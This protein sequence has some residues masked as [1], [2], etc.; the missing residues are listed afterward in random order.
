MPSIAFFT[1][2]S[3]FPWSRQLAGDAGL[4]GEWRFTLNEI[5]EDCEFLV[6]YDEVGQPFETSLP[7]ERRM[8]ILSEPPGIKTYHPA[9]LDQFGIVM[10]PIEPRDFKGRWIASH[11]ALPWFLGIGFGK[12]GLEVNLDLEALRA[13]PCPPKLNAISVVISS[14]A[15]LPKHRARLAFVEKLQARLGEQLHVFG[16]GFREIDDKAEAILPYAYHLVLENNDIPHFWTE[17]TADAYLGWALPI[18][19]GCAN[20]SHYVPG[21]SLV[22][23]D[24][25]RPEE[26]LAMIE[27][28]IEGHPW[29]S[30][31]PQIAEGRRRI[32]YEHDLATVLTRMADEI[33]RSAG[34]SV[35]K[36]RL[37]Q[38]DVISPNKKKSLIGSLRTTVKQMLSSSRTGHSRGA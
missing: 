25:E 6:V 20:L 10:G 38:P 2:H 9:Y 33:A 5:A 24:I 14:K 34:L 12:E 18:F 13:L 4:Q 8:V 31:L 26:A 29:E 16:R 7:R 1:A 28:I 3:R 36:V 30:R 17:K 37:R 23:V 11:P 21:D 32:A 35:P 27:G 22:A 19:S 15:Q